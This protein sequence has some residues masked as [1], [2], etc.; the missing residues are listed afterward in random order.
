MLMALLV[1]RKRVR[2]LAGLSAAGP[3]IG[4]GRFDG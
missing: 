1:A 2:F 4:A 3:L